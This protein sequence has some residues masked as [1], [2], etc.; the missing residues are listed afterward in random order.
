MVE[1]IR[2]A[3]RVGKLG[4]KRLARRARVGDSAVTRLVRRD[5]GILGEDI[6]KLHQAAEDLLARKR[7]E[8]EQIAAVLEWAKAQP[9]SRLAAQLGGYDLSNLGKVLAGRIRP[10]R[11]L[12]RM[13]ELQ[14]SAQESSGGRTA[15][16]TISGARGTGRGE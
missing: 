14:R 8:D 5:S 2:Y 3:V 4:V 9:R 12:A 13:A 15:A 6:L 11:V 7:A 10:K 16:E 1:A